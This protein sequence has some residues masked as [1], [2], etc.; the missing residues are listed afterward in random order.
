MKSAFLAIDHVEFEEGNYKRVYA[1]IKDKN[2]EISCGTK[3]VVE[4]FKNIV[5]I[6][7]EL[8]YEISY[9]S[10]V[11]NFISDNKGKYRYENCYLVEN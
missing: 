4:D 9:S 8:G 5:D 6:L 7:F 10:T 2:I 3:N 1:R 11:D